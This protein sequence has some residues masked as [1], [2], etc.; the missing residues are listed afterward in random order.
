MNLEYIKGIPDFNS[1]TNFASMFENAKSFNDDVSHWNTENVTSMNK[2]FKGAS[3]FNQPIGMWN[4]RNVTSLEAMFEDASTFN[5]PISKWDVRRVTTIRK[6]FSGARKFN[7]DLTNWKL[8]SVSLNNLQFGDFDKA[9]TDWNSSWKPKFGVACV[10]RVEIVNSNGTYTEGD[11]L[12]FKIHFD[13]IVSLQGGYI[14]AP[15]PK[16]ELEFRGPNKHAEYTGGSDTKT[17]NFQYSVVKGDISYRLNYSSI[18]ALQPHPYQIASYE[19]P[20]NAPSYSEGYYP[21]I[22]SLFEGE[23]SMGVKKNVFVGDKQAFISLWNTSKTS[24]GSTSNKTIKLPFYEGGSYNFNIDWGD[25]TIQ[26]VTSWNS[27]NTTHTY[28]QEGVYKIIIKGTLKGF[29]FN[30]QGDRNKLIQILNW[31]NMNLGNKGAYFE[32]A[33]SLTDIFTPIIDLEGTSNFSKMFKG[34]S[35]FNHDLSS[36]NTENVKDMSSMFNGASSFNGDVSSWDV[37]VVED[38]SS[39]FNGASSFNSDVSSWNVSKVVDMQSMFNGASS[40]NGDVSSWD[41]SVVEDMSSMFN[42]ASSFN[43]DVGGWNVSKV[44]DMQSMFNRCFQF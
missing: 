11:L 36:W 38:M 44:V 17:L 40:F 15:L 8:C 7:Q 25:G 4:L 41:V 3:K 32:G 42:G 12:Q 10:N 21:A 2:M 29:R 39:M 13:R 34:A 22:L 18:N 33:E 28:D 27:P 9:T 26:H 37:S 16:L 35:E 1:T 24:E 20:V 19:I 30:N 14:G 31:G 6:T 5:Q 23:E 43:S